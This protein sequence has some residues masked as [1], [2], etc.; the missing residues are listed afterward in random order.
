[1]NPL[2]RN[3][4]LDG[5]SPEA[6]AQVTALDSLDEQAAHRGEL[7]QRVRTARGMRSISGLKLLS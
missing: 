5:A 7:V 1:M 2:D 6:G 3:P 4:Y